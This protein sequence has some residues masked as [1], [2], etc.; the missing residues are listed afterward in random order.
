MSD[1]QFANGGGEEA[2]SSC[3]WQAFEP[4]SSGLPE[5]DPCGRCGHGESLS[6]VC[7]TEAM[8]KTTAAMWSDVKYSGPW[9]SPGLFCEIVQCG[10][11]QALLHS[12]YD[13][14]DSTLRTTR[15][16][17]SIST[18]VH[19]TSNIYT[20]LISAVLFISIATKT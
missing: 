20:C 6:D 1:D 16:Y 5:S 12:V 15:L 10:V 4:S 7:V 3:I 9:R 11:P 17:V 8:I 18:S 14:M 2:E 13:T 19:T